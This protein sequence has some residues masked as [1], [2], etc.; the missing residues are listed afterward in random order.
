MKEI[1]F[2]NGG[3]NLKKMLLRKAIELN[4]NDLKTLT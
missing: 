2:S 4:W 1:H 3:Y